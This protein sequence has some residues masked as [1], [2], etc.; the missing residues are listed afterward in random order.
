MKSGS[1]KYQDVKSRSPRRD[2]NVETV[3]KK[4]QDVNSASGKIEM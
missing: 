4:D 3:S 2:Q 1:R